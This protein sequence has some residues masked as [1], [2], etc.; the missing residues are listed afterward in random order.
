MTNTYV[1]STIEI[2][3]KTGYDADHVAAQYRKAKELPW[4]SRVEEY[5]LMELLGDLHGK[6]VVDV[7]CH[8]VY[9]T[10]RPGI[11]ATHQ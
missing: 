6:R 11:L 5:P 2:T 10:R 3:M 9:S 8:E 7:A 1:S 4:R